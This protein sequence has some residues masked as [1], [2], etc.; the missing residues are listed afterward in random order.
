MEIWKHDVIRSN[1][2]QRPY[3][4]LDR[5]LQGAKFS[6]IIP[7]TDNNETFLVGQ[8]RYPVEYYSWEFPM[9][10]AIGKNFLEVAKIELKE[11]V[12]IVANKW[13]EIGQFYTAPGHSSEKAGVFI[14]KDLTFQEN[15][16]SGEEIIVV[17]RMSVKKVKQMIDK[18]MILDGPT[19]VA[20]HYLEVYLERNIK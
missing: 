4:V 3:Y 8:Y 14:A 5:D 1:G 9:G 18:G 2:N 13:V 10:H 12:G 15:N 6:I 16:P 17:D 19:I 20:Y 11:E 7:L